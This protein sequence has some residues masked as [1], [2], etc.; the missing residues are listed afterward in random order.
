M[1]LKPPLL[2]LDQPIVSYTVYF[3]RSI[4]LKVLA[5]MQWST[6]HL[7]PESILASMDDDMIVYVPNLVDYLN[8]MFKPRMNQT[9]SLPPCYQDLPIVCV[10]KIKRKDAPE[11]Y[12]YS[13][14][15]VSQEEYPGSTWPT[16][17]RG[18]L[19][20]MSNKMAT[21]VF[22]ASRT[23]AYL[24]MDDVWITGFMRRKLEQGDCNIMVSGSC[25]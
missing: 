10:H 18:G 4:G 6:T 13:K 22:E 21:D 3:F 23:T 5:G 11:R 15:Y 14:W 1:E 20:L 9:K 25:M 8:D 16:Y 17:C 19:Y 7:S 24:S 2:L 12:Y